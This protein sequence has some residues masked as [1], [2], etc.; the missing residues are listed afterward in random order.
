MII[1]RIREKLNKPCQNLIT[2]ECRKNVKDLKPIYDFQFYQE[3]KNATFV[4]VK[5]PNPF[6]HHDQKRK[7]HNK[8]KPSKTVCF[9]YPG[10]FLNFNTFKR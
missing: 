2:Y 6:P 4:C 10:D 8:E 3:Q 7:N 9:Q 1:N 5:H